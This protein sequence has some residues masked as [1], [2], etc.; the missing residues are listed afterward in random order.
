MTDQQLTKLKD[1]LQHV[2]DN[3]SYFA[4][5]DLLEINSDILEAVKMLRAA[6]KEISNDIQ[7]EFNSNGGAD[8]LLKNNASFEDSDDLASSSGK[9]I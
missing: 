2:I 3:D 5:E 7:I 1:H 8:I 9:P 6:A 4:K